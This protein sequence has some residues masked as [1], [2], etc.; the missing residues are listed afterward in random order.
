M[1]HINAIS[2]SHNLLLNLVVRETTNW[3]YLDIVPKHD[4]VLASYMQSVPTKEFFRFDLKTSSMIIYFPILYHSLTGMHS[5][6]DIPSCCHTKNN[7][8]ILLEV[9]SAIEL[10]LREA[11]SDLAPNIV[12]ELTENID[13]RYTAMVA[14]LLNSIV[15][16]SYILP[17]AEQ[18]ELIQKEVNQSLLKRYSTHF[19]NESSDCSGLKVLF[20]IITVFAENKRTQVDKAARLWVKQYTT[21]LIAMVLENYLTN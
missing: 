9:E 19:I 14:T 4:E 10:I 2:N 6:G 12:H 17:A 8:I 18:K 3:Y 20:Q 5:F 15:P 11:F 16:E 21:Q 13:G 7:S 1:N